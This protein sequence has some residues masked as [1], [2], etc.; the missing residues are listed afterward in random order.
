M[1][2]LY[3]C[4][5]FLSYYFIVYLEIMLMFTIVELLILKIDIYLEIKV[6]QA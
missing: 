4:F 6:N 2:V 3:I 1:C 5:A